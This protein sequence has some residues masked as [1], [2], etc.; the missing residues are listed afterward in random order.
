M[1]INWLLLAAVQ[2]PAEEIF[3]NANP[4]RTTG[5]SLLDILLVA[6]M[7]SIVGLLLFLLAYLTH[8]RS[9]RRSADDGRTAIYGSD[10]GELDHRRRRHRKRRVEHP[11]NLPRNP[12]LAEA[13]GLPPIRPEDPSAPVQKAG[14]LNAG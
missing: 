11:D 6:G 9:R 7:I 3:K 5:M 10:K 12:T 8:K 2:D 14:P 1:L 13:G 4:S